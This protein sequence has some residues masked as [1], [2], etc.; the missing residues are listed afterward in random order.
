MRSAW[1]NPSRSSISNSS[2]ASAPPGGAVLGD[3][4]GEPRPDVRGAPPRSELLRGQE[5]EAPCQ[6]DEL[7]PGVAAIEQRVGE[8]L[9]R[10]VARR[11][12][13]RTRDRYLLALLHPLIRLSH[14]KMYQILHQ[15]VPLVEIPR[16]T[17]IGSSR[18]IRLRPSLEHEFRSN[19]NQDGRGAPARGIVATQP[20]RPPTRS[21][22]PAAAAP[23]A[24]RIKG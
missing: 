23:H 3:E 16:R 8:H 15:D 9:E 24:Q 12:V 19:T 7:T 6:R 5:L 14:E 20:L 18:W 13:E 11:R 22:S 2:P 4:L 21:A 17:T 1:M 10:G